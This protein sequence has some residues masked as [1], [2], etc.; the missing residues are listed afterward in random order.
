MSSKSKLGQEGEEL[1]CKYLQENGHVILEKN[2]RSGHLEIDIISFDNK[3]LHFVEVKT[4]VNP[5]SKP[6][7]AVN[8]IKQ[9][10]LAK[11]AQQ[12]L[13]KS[14]N[15]LIFDA[16]CFFDIIAISFCGNKMELKYFPEAFIPMYY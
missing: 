1:A 12:Y 8:A 16:E 5:V 11:A 9:K 2:Y 4:R 10:R 13:R 15:P 6:E 3:G 7:E 14:K